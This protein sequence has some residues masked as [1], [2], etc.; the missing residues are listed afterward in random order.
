MNMRNALR[1]M[2][3]L[4]GLLALPLLA[5]EPA[6]PA[7]AETLYVSHGERVPLRAQPDPSAAVTG[8]LGAGAAVTVTGRQAGFASVAAGNKTGWI[9]ATDLSSTAPPRLQVSQL[10]SRL[11]RLESES[12]ARIGELEADNTSLQQQLR[13][14]QANARNARSNLEESSSEQTAELNDARA[15]IDQLESQNASLRE[16]L[17]TAEQQIDTLKL[18][19]DANAMLQRVPTRARTAERS[20]TLPSL[21]WL[22][23]SG[24][25]LLLGGIVFGIH[26]RNRQLRKRY[27]GMEL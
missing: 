22:L 11:D 9:L 26:W 14:A 15:R 3:L 23:G 2:L 10:Q 24:L 16:A 1:G 19:N 5:G 6:T 27:H 20:W 18:A 4:I 17:E 13:T 12:A 25:G 7:A 21:P 8:Y